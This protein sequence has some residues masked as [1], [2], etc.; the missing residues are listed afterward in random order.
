[1]LQQTFLHIP[2]IGPMTERR[3]W[4][5]GCLSWVDYIDAPTSWDLSPRLGR[6]IEQFLKESYDSLAWG[7]ARY[8]ERLLPADEVWRLLPEFSHRT[9]YL[10]IETTGLYPGPEAITVIGLFDGKEARAFVKG[11]DLDDFAPEIRKYSLVVTYNGKGFDIPFLRTRYGNLFD[12]IAHLDLRWEL[13]RLGYKGGLKSIER[14]LGAARGEGLADVDGRMAVLLWQEHLRGTGG[15]LET[16]IRY[17]LEDVVGLKPLAAL[18]Y[19][20]RLTHLPIAVS[21]LAVAERRQPSV[22]FDPHLIEVL[23][24]RLREMGV[25]IAR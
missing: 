6:R 3:L 2:G 18:A 13:H 5:E 4:S 14:Q 20:M 11:I 15:A 16:L 8:F 10:D 19:N 24:K 9:A 1:M 12:G 23:T 22:P 21:P 25:P 17:N 7:D